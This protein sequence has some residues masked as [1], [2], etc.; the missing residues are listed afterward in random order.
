MTK[1]DSSARSGRQAGVLAA[2]VAVSRLSRRVI[3]AAAAV[4]SRQTRLFD[5]VTN[6]GF[7]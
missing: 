6:H 1:V 4:F 3:A 7:E 5:C 2:P